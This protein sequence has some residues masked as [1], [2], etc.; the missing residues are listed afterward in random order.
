MISIV[1]AINETG[2]TSADELLYPENY[3]YISNFLSYVVVGVRSVENQEH[4]PT[5]SGLDIPVE[6]KNPTSGNILV[7]MNAITALQHAHEII[8][9]GWEVYSKGNL[10][11]HAILRGYMNKYGK[12]FPNYHYEDLVRFCKEY[13]SHELTNPSIITDTNHFK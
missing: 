1:I 4:I 11:A 3:R 12:A 7:M 5:A 10:F 9:R 8:Y 2:L 6:M 13:A